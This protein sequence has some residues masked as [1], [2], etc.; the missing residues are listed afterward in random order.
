MK[1]EY[2]AYQEEEDKFLRELGLKEE[3][4]EVLPPIDQKQC[5]YY[6]GGFDTADST[7]SLA[8]HIIYH[9]LSPSMMQQWVIHNI[10]AKL[11]TFL[12]YLIHPIAANVFRSIK[13][14]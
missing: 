6:D 1:Q 12:K 4:P 7:V 8:H 2:H 9:F 14:S 3:A 10:A 5:M 11:L 13:Y